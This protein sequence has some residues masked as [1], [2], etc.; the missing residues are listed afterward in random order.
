LRLIDFAPD[1][2]L[3][4]D[5][6]QPIPEMHDRIIVGLARRLDAPLITAD[7]IISSAGVVN[8]IW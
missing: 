5:Q 1:D 2:V 3:D 8:V 6:D 4:F 7:A